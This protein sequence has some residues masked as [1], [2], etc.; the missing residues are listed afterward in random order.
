MDGSLKIL[1][2]AS[3][4][5]NRRDPRLG[6]FVQRHAE[7][8]SARHE[9]F[10]VSA[11]PHSEPF[12]DRIQKGKLTEYVVHYRN[13]LPLISYFWSIRKGIKMAK[14]HAG[15][16]DI[17]HVNVAWPAGL[18]AMFLGLPYIVSE[19]FSGYLPQRKYKWSPPIKYFTRKILEKAQVVIPVSE[20]LKKA[21]AEFAPK[22]RFSVIPNVVNDKLFKYQPPP[23]D[24]MFTFVHIS[25]LENESKNISGMTDAL[26]KVVRRGRSDFIV[27]IGGD[28]NM[29]VLED[30]IYGN[31]LPTHQFIAIPAQEPHEVAELIANSHALIM[32]SHYE[33]QSCTILEA[34]C[35]GRPVVTSAVGGIPEITDESNSLQMEDDDRIEFAK[36]IERMIDN[37]HRFNTREISEKA[38]AKFSFEAVAKQYDEVYF[39]VLKRAP[40]S[41]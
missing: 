26:R 3:W 12:I 11:I 6:N 20:F 9:V 19:H 17:C 21:M 1:F 10:A 32:F 35:S 31:A 28:G 2:L 41:R 40:S 24:G 39:S 30:H 16:F 8:I 22:A 13:E 4:Y 25:S 33:T 27:K 7:A 23:K 29:R 36:S 34:L 37:Y 15:E 14:K 18:V 5:P 38:L